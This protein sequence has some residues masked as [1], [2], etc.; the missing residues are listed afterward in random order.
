MVPTLGC[1]STCFAALLI[2]K[3]LALN[4]KYQAHFLAKIQKDI[5]SKK[6]EEF[7]VSN[8]LLGTHV[9]SGICHHGAMG[10]LGLTQ[11]VALCAPA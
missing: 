8:D 5:I 7:C 1:W 3:I 9:G 2:F 4:A 11:P 6:T 10:K